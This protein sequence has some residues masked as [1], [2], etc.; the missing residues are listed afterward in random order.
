MKEFSI[1]LKEKLKRFDFWILGSSIG[2]T[3]LSVI[4]LYAASDAVG[5]KR[6]VIQ[7]FAMVMG[8]QSGRG[9]CH[10]AWPMLMYMSGS[11]RQIDVISRPVISFQS[12]RMK[13][14]PPIMDTRLSPSS[15]RS[16]ANARHSS[17]DRSPSLALPPPEPQ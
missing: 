2:M 13:T 6:P 1:N 14:S 9:Q 15:A 10:R 8:V 17:A 5:S 12:G 16:S 11:S 7:F 4:T 3:L